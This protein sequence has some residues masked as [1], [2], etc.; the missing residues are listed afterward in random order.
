MKHCENNLQNLSTSWNP[1]EIDLND[2]TILAK[3]NYTELLNKSKNL[4]VE[5]STSCVYFQNNDMN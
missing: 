5:L 2:V 4:A 1:I 3:I